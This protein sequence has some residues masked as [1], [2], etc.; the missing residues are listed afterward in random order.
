MGCS[1]WLTMVMYDIFYVNDNYK[2][3]ET[4]FNSFKRYNYDI[5]IGIIEFSEQIAI[6][7]FSNPFTTDTRTPYIYIYIPLLDEVNNGD[8]VSTCRSIHVSSTVYY[9]THI[10]TMSDLTLNSAS[11][12]AST[13]EVYTLVSNHSSEKEV[14]KYGRRYTSTVIGYCNVSVRNKRRCF[15]I[16]L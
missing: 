2:L 6:D 4:I 5:L 10:S 14:S 13:L 11:S 9:S 16:T 3:M 1:V 12:S 7:F 15:S 8:T